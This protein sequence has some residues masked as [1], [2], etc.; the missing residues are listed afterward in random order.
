[1][2][3]YA[4]RMHFAYFAQVAVEG[5]LWGQV[6]YGVRL[7]FRTFDVKLPPW[8]ANPAYIFLQPC[9]TLSFAVMPVIRFS[10]P[11]RIGIALE[12]EGNRHF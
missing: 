4:V 7:D 12:R 6:T 10:F 2:I 11:I 8:L 5:H 9:I 3:L 1:M